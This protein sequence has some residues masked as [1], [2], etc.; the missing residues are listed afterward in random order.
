M[1]LLSA[2]YRCPW[3]CR[4]GIVRLGPEEQ[5]LKPFPLLRPVFSNRIVFQRRALRQHDLRWSFPARAE[6]LQRQDLMWVSGWV[7]KTQTQTKVEFVPHSVDR[8]I[9]STRTR[10]NRIALSIT[11]LA[12][13]H[14]VE[15]SNVY[16]WVE[17]HAC[18]FRCV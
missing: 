8:C 15:E 5:Q 14:L 11:T 17:D 16:F 2:Q 18:S 12:S 7:V 10:G 4:G 1:S 3:P 6:K 9:H 13:R